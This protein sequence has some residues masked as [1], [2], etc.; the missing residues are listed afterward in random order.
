[1]FASI[2]MDA[3]QEFIRAIAEVVENEG[4][5]M[6]IGYMCNI[7]TLHRLRSLAC[8]TPEIKWLIDEAEREFPNVD[9]QY[10]D[11]VL[12]PEEMSQ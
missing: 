5:V 1:M 11:L 10:I 8:R 2:Y 7:I 12:H 3:D 9:P 4:H 6:G